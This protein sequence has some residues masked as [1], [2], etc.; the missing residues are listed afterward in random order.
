MDTQ[1]YTHTHSR[2]NSHGRDIG[3]SQRHLPLQHKYSQQM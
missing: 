1:T 3:P 2:W